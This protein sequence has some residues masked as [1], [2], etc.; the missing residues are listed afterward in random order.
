MCNNAG[1]FGRSGAVR[2]WF[3]QELQSWCVAGGTDRINLSGGSSNQVFAIF[4]FGSSQL[5]S[6]HVACVVAGSAG[7]LAISLHGMASGTA[8]IFGK[9]RQRFF[10]AQSRDRM[11]RR[12]ADDERSTI[13]WVRMG[14]G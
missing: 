10:M 4:Y 12:D 11:E 6:S 3:V 2:V 1:G 7:V 5:A 13:D 14:E 9:Q 8:R